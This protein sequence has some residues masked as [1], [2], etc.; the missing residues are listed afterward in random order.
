MG[1]IEKNITGFSEYPV[2]VFDASSIIG[3]SNVRDAVTQ[4][5]LNLHTYS[6]R[7]AKT[8]QAVHVTVRI[9]ERAEE[10]TGLQRKNVTES[11]RLYCP[12]HN[13]IINHSVN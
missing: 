11:D 8:V 4:R 5:T 3:G 1:K 7:G 2:V 12:I 10:P 6:I 9:I 13:Q